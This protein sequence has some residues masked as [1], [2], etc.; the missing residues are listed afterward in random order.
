MN[1]HLLSLF[2]KHFIPLLSDYNFH[3]KV[4]NVT[5]Q[6]WKGSVRMLG[7]FSGTL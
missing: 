2:F 1:P 5:L 3:V 4:V 7:P 6:K